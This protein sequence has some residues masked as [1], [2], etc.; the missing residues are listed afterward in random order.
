MTIIEIAPAEAA[1]YLR[2]PVEF[3]VLH[4]T[5][6]LDI[7]LDRLAEEPLRNACGSKKLLF[8]CQS[9]TRGGK[10]CESAAKMGL[11]PNQCDGRH[12]GMAARG[13]SVQRGKQVMSLERHVR[14]ATGELVAVGP[15]AGI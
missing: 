12:G 5:P 3:A 15:L 10:A 7:P 4:A 6:A 2:T 13:L 11:L 14:I 8:I 9:G 1:R